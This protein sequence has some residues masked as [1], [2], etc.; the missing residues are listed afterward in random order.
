MVSCRL[1]NQLL[2]RRRF[3]GPAP[4]HILTVGEQKLFESFVPQPHSEKNQVSELIEPQH[5]VDTPHQLQ[6]TAEKRFHSVPSDD[7]HE[8]E[9]LC[10][11]ALVRPRTRAWTPLSPLCHSRGSVIEPEKRSALNA[12]EN[13][14]PTRG[15][16]S[17]DGSAE[18][19]SPRM[20]GC[21][22]L[23]KE[24]QLPMAEVEAL[25]A[26]SVHTARAIEAMKRNQ[27]ATGTKFV[28]RD[29]ASG[30]RGVSSPIKA[31]GSRKNIA[32][33]RTCRR[34]NVWS[35]CLCCYF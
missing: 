8:F 35:A 34:R 20:Y 9:L 5:R 32:R 19:V 4:Q 23:N 24:L 16:R 33:K 14:R 27:T 21:F 15:S 7:H 25:Q 26:Q 13:H 3:F 12:M 6:A 1:W 10:R 11:R 28:A 29:T 17:D 31:T 2:V 18:S 30:A 22:D